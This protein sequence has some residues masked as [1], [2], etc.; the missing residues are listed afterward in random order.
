MRLKQIFF[1]LTV[2]LL[3]ACSSK[4]NVITE[5]YPK[6]EFRGAWIQAVNGQF[7]GMDERQMK[8]YLVKMLDNLQKVNVNAIIFQVRV[9]GDALYP[10]SIEPWSR[11][12]T[13]VQGRS[14]EWDPLAFMVD[15]CHRRNM[16]LHAWIN[17]YRARTKGTK[18]VAPNH[19][20]KRR[21]ESVVE[22]E[23]QFYFNP[24]L[25]S[26]RDHI[27]KVVTDIVD[28]YDVDGIHI[29]DYFYPYPTKGKEF[30]DAAYFPK[31]AY[32]DKSEWR[33]E[34]VNHLI[35]QLHRTVRARKPWVKFGVSPF[36]IYRNESSDPSGSKTK[37]LQC[38]D[39]LNAD[40]LFWIERGWV[41]YCIPQ[42]YWEIGHSA[43]DY[44][45]L[46]KWW[47]KHAS[48]RPL[49]IGQDVQRTVKAKD[50]TSVTG[51]Q[52]AA[53]YKMQRAE[54][55]ISGSCFWDAASAADNVD[56]YRDYLAKGTFRYP[57][58][59]PHYS[60]IDNSA[61]K[62]VKGVHLI[63]DAGK[64]V[65]VWI[66]D[67]KK[68][69]EVMNA[70]YRYVVYCFAKGEKVNT[71]SPANIVAIT[72]KCYYELPADAEGTMT[73]VVTV[74]D[75]MQNESAGRKCKVQL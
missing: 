39:D 44:A 51:N 50:N 26:N 18:F 7:M 17:P 19:L 10:S 6:R 52:Q 32:A 48:K 34:N 11:Y 40:V 35:Y 23:G 1:V 55:N 25:Q 45:E 66:T 33:R 5:H 43:A 61:P 31:N 20:S 73:F 9:E 65:L 29:D 69:K 21:P 64:K 27:C 49:Y 4:K 58:L 72:D 30:N 3:A 47:A 59:M 15:E 67:S 75:R 74:L 38:Y 22:Y 68:G 24:A 16:E 46:V 53:K 12:L 57:S 14:P 56:G 42:V 63:D 54:E 13:G 70:P 71:D 28:R 36:G 62:K 8:D 37:G 60:F 2:L 41:D